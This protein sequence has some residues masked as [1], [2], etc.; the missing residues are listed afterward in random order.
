MARM[1]GRRV[2]FRKG[3][4]LTGIVGALL[5]VI[6][7]LYVSGQLLE[8]FGEAMENTCSPFYTGFQL[9]G[10]APNGDTPPCIP[11]DGHNSGGVLNVVG[12]VALAY[13]VKKVIYIKR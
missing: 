3:V 13:V 10:W 2:G 7:S 8:Q 6:I 1:F 5:A 4:S 11:Q 9:I 12:I